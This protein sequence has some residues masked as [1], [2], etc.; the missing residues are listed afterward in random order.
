VFVALSDYFLLV[1]LIEVALQIY[2]F[3]VVGFNML[4][5]NSQI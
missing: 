2:A 3:E 5:K 4:I 1:K